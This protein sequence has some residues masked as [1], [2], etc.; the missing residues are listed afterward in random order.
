MALIV[1]PKTKQQEKIVKAFLQSLSIG[2]H[3][4]AEEDSALLRA[5]EKGRN[6]RLLTT[7]QKTDFLKR[8]KAAK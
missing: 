1:N 5:M 8:L 2:F 3:S 6:S 4:E 7:T